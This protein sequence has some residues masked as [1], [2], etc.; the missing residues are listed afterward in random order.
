MKTAVFTIGFAG[1]CIA[2]FLYLYS[3]RTPSKIFGGTT[4]ATFQ[5]GT[6]TTSNRFGGILFADGSV[7]RQA[8]S[9]G[10][11][12]YDPTAQRFTTKYASTTGVTV[13]G[14]FFTNA[15]TAQ[16]DGLSS[17][18]LDFQSGGDGL[19]IRAFAS[20]GIT[21]NSSGGNIIYT[22][23]NATIGNANGGDVQ[24]TAGDKVG[25]GSQGQ[26]LFKSGGST[27]FA[28]LNTASIASSD[29]IFT[30]PN[31]TGTF[32]LNVGTAPA[33]RSCGTASITATSTDTRGTIS[34][35][36]G[37]PTTCNI[38]FSSAKSDTPTCV[39]STNS[40]T[41][42][43]DVALAS[44]TGVQFGLTAGFSGRIHYLCLL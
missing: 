37:T 21:S 1:L 19:D 3:Q 28:D 35:T 23:G 24:F 29:K 41:L 38:T 22:A 12:D 16:A 13:S 9:T 44:T 11:L 8:S 6:G 15:I 10:L 7:F 34:V 4:V 40:V 20:N 25:G 42:L 39:V 30:F 2:A 31:Y 5:G 36:A 26:L 14:T 32:L 27:Q 17:G 18:Q 33:L 43:G